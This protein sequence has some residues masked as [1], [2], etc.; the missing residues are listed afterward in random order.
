MN[1]SVGLTVLQ[2]DF[3]FMPDNFLFKPLP[4]AGLILFQL[5]LLIINVSA[6]G[7]FG[8]PVKLSPGFR[9]VFAMNLQY[10]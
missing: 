10:S 8:F 9:A 7:V 6:H 4:L 3:P 5:V 1:H 2:K